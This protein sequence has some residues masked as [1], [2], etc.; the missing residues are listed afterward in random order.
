M[1]PKFYYTFIISFFLGIFAASFFENFLAETLFLLLIF[2]II[3]ISFSFFRKKMPRYF[4]FSFIFVVA[5]SLGAVRMEIF[6]YYNVG[7]FDSLL[8]KKVTKKLVVADEPEKKGY[9]TKLILKFQNSD[10][11]AL[12]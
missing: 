3:F 8:D 6:N 11:K 1:D 9:H 7:D 2:F 10:S 12:M 5:F 4:I